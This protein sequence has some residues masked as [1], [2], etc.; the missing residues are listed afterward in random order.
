MSDLLLDISVLEGFREDKARKNL[1]EAERMM[2]Q[3]I[4]SLQSILKRYY[5]LSVLERAANESANTSSPAKI[6]LP[7]LLQS[8][9]QTK[10]MR[11]ETGFSS[12]T[13]IKESDWQKITL[14]SEDFTRRLLRYIDMYSLLCVKDG[15]L[16][17]SLLD[18]YRNRLLSQI[19]PT[20]MDETG[21]SAVKT[22]IKAFTKYYSRDVEEIFGTTSE[23]LC[24]DLFLLLDKC[25]KTSKEMQQRKLAHFTELQNEV[26]KRVNNGDMRG[27]D[28][29]MAEVLRNDPDYHRFDNTFDFYMVELDSNLPKKTLELFTMGLGDGDEAYF[30]G[31][32]LSELNPFIGIAGLHYCFVTQH[33][34]YYIIKV[35]V[36]IVKEKR[37]N[38]S[39]SETI[40]QLMQFVAE[41]LFRSHNSVYEHYD[42]KS[43]SFNLIPI[44]LRN[45]FDRPE[46]FTVIADLTSDEFASCKDTV[47]N[48]LVDF[49]GLA[50]LTKL[51]DN[52]YRFS[53]SYL[54][55]LLE[56]KARK[57][58]FFKEVFGAVEEE[59]LVVDDTLSD[60]FD[61]DA[62]KEED[63]DEYDEV[64]DINTSDEFE[65]DD[66]DDD[67]KAESIEHHYDDLD[68]LPKEYVHKEMSEEERERM[69]YQYE[70][71]E[72]LLKAQE[73][74]AENSS[75]YE[76]SFDYDQFELPEDEEKEEKESE[77]IEKET[78]NSTDYDEIFD[79]EEAHQTD[80]EELYSFVDVDDEDETTLAVFDEDETADDS[81]QLSLFDADGKMSSDIYREAKKVQEKKEEPTRTLSYLF[82]PGLKKKA[83]PVEIFEANEDS[84]AD[85]VNDDVIENVILDE[86]SVI[87]E[88][89][90]ASPVSEPATEEPTKVE[91]SAILVDDETGEPIEDEE[92]ATIE[93]QPAEEPATKVVVS[94]VLVDDETG[95]P[96]ED[97]EPAT[98]EEQPAEEPAT[99]VVVSAVLVDDET[100]EPIEDEEP[101]TIEEQPA[102]EPAT[103][104]VV[105]A[106]LVDDETEE[107]IEEPVA[108]EEQPTEESVTETEVSPAPVEEESSSFDSFNDD[109]NEETEH[110]KVVEAVELS[111][112]EKIHLSFEEPKAEAP[113]ERTALVGFEIR[114]VVE[115]EKTYPTIIKQLLAKAPQG[116]L[117]AFFEKED[118]EML[119]GFEE[120]IATCI[121]QQH[122]NNKDKIFSI[123]P[124]KL[125]VIV[126]SG[127]NID[128][129]R[130]SELLNNA[131]AVMY[132]EGED[133]WNVAVLM[134][135]E[136]G[137]LEHLQEIEI[138]QRTFSDYDWRV[139]KNMAQK[140]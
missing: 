56:D 109:Q 93:E 28:A 40:E 64:I 29:I 27:E 12:N 105:S 111:E 52:V 3:E 77:E 45:Y 138:G 70:L 32:F 26:E 85:E 8:I 76:D 95:E 58:E 101:A 102:E 10:A 114:D 99:K 135:N 134:F 18:S 22:M 60:I 74:E 127:K 119:S 7:Y 80:D 122:I 126:T 43:I 24:H 90:P 17:K 112:E 63:E 49:E 137:E 118:A 133:G 75:E 61:Y 73:Q 121:E 55:S 11:I 66:Q 94:A 44:H 128:S 106:V 25:G 84:E 103:K 115:E 110:V 100:G 19:F 88:E 33:L 23:Q 39:V 107:P 46:K 130:N 83:E 9:L 104:V 16:P 50:P 129:L 68:V 15:R 108:I 14:F 5:P 34:P 124:Y 2:R 20:A 132:S 92:P 89:T 53:L 67:A 86:K 57:N 31:T 6:L 140:R 72:E 117:K 113:V 87:E 116:P 125:S 51:R 65:Y 62:V 41:G 59:K 48:F 38:V 21:I 136:M 82:M 71:P 1:A 69:N 131:G 37:P 35:L 91:V 54:L 139:V 81:E 98:I 30:N 36:R 123:K 120:A 13:Q 4:E 79:E 96:I 97:E 42:G 47:V 78:T